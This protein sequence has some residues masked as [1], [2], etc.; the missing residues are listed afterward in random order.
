[1]TSVARVEPETFRAP[2]K[3]ATVR[4]ALAGCG[5]VGSALLRELVTRRETM[6]RRHGVEVVV[7]R[8]LVRDADRH[9]PAPLDRALLTTDVDEFLATDADVV[10]EAIGGL[11]PAGRIARVALARG[12]D[13]VTANKE[14]LAAHGTELSRLAARHRASLRYDAAVGGGVPILRLLATHSAPARRTS[15]GAS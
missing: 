14:L 13:V 8:I 5:A 6:A 12:R 10:V 11:D 3:P 15:C 2:R 7:A 1:M 4:V 9:R